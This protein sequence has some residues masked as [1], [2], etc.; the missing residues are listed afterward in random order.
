[1]KKY[2]LFLLIL[3][4]I[5]FS[6]ETTDSD[7][8]LFKK[9][10]T[11]YLSFDGYFRFQYFYR[12]NFDLN[13]WNRDVNS[14]QIYGSSQYLPTLNEV[15]KGKPLDDS[16]ISYNTRFRFSPILNVGEYVQSIFTLDVFDN[17]LFGTDVKGDKLAVKEGYAI[18]KTPFGKVKL[19]RVATNWG[20]GI[21]RNDGKSTQAN[22]GSYID[23]LYFETNPIEVLLPNFKASLSY[24]VSESFPGQN[25]SNYS[26]SLNYDR[27]DLDDKTEWVL[28]LRDEM[29]SEKRDEYLKSGKNLFEW[30]IFASYG[31]R[32]NIY[33]TVDPSTSEAIDNYNSDDY[34]A[35]T[36]DAFLSFYSG[37]F[38]SI[39]SE[40]V[41]ITGDDNGSSFNKWGGAIETNLSFL[42]NTLKFGIDAGVASGDEDYDTYNTVFNGSALPSGNFRFAP[43]YQVD[44]IFLKQ[45][46]ILTDL[47]Y[48]KPHV[49]YNIHPTITLDFWSV[50]TQALKNEAT[51]GRD[52][53]L[54]LEFDLQVQYVTSDGINFG[55]AAGLFIPGAG[56]DW[57]GS[58]KERNGDDSEDNK[59]FSAE[60][61]YSLSSFLIIK[62]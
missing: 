38:F 49:T 4:T 56:M 43:D 19:G 42:A 47:F 41:W 5:L 57:L 60:I 13:A 20:L 50:Y 55:I 24:E 53:Y 35:Y 31:S 39:K 16:V 62:F 32:D 59:D 61:A 25:P 29:D 10:T 58:N 2:L 3:P 6:V 22:Y 8:L 26:S 48:V 40:L 34:S 15:H 33:Q 27:E 23:Q 37:R 45:I 1:M 9:E 18:L 54:G 21:F 51:F 44:L 52:P 30:G 28:T 46:G 12:D 17:S 7:L 36:L 11:K 14:G